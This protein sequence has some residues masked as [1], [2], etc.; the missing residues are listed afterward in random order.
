LV[1]THQLCARAAPSTAWPFPFWL[2]IKRRGYRMGLGSFEQRKAKKPNEAAAAAELAGLMKD[3]DGKGP[4][5]PD[6]AL[7]SR[8]QSRW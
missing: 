7:L 2:V 4:N 8:R 6:F 5:F 1:G 3:R